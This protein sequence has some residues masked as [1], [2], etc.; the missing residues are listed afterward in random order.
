MSTRSDEEHQRDDLQTDDN[1]KR[2]EDLALMEEAIKGISAHLP[3]MSEKH[4]AS[5]GVISIA[6]GEDIEENDDER[7]A[8]AQLQHK[9][10][11]SSNI[12]NRVVEQI[13]QL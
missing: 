10:D 9:K 7:D 6:S 4:L 3:A 1:A 5:R 13:K 12:S 11:M 2:K 8:G